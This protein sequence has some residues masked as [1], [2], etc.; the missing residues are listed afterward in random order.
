MFYSRLF[1]FYRHKPSLLYDTLVESYWL[2][3]NGIITQ[4]CVSDMMKKKSFLS[5]YDIIS[6]KHHLIENIQNYNALFV[7]KYMILFFTNWVEE[8]GER[9]SITTTEKYK[10]FISDGRTVQ[11]STRSQFINQLVDELSNEDGFR[12]MTKDDRKAAVALAMQN[13][14][15]T[16]ATSKIDSH[17][18]DTISHFLGIKPISETVDT[19]YG[20]QRHSD[21]LSEMYPN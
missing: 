5:Y 9:K 10:L 3:S 13:K 18:L 19:L 20:R 11:N 17:Y 7:I 14:K 1:L 21:P 16:I 15:L 8:D 12:D 4:G 2:K 6:S